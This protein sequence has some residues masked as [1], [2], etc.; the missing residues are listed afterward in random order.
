MVGKGVGSKGIE[1]QGLER[2]LVKVY[3][4]VS[5]YR[6][7]EEALEGREECGEGVRKHL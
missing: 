7:G 1:T 4:R 3:A 5:M 2:V 6:K